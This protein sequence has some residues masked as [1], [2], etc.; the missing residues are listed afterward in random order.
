MSGRRWLGAL[1]A[2]LIASPAAAAPRA[3]LSDFDVSSVDNW[4]DALALCDLTA[5]LRTRPSLDAHVILAPDPSTG[6]LRP[7]E[8]PRFLP[9]GLFTSRAMKQSFERLEQ[10]GEINRRSFSRARARHDQPMFDSYRRANAAD[11]A[12]LDEQWSLCG[13]FAQDI[14]ERFPE[15]PR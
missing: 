3:R 7:L 13:F 8:G 1:L 14:S 11:L 6:W 12:F 10:S 15:R 2:L 5:F 9:L 4:P